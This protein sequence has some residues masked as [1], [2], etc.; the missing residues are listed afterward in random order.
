MKKD[1]I[2]LL[3]EECCDGM[4]CKHCGFRDTDLHCYLTDIIKI[5]KR[6]ELL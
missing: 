2:I 6:S 3:I 4:S 5:I 1:L